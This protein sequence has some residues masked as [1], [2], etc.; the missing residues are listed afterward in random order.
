MGKKC[1]IEFSSFW[2]IYE[3]SAVFA[4]SG[5]DPTHA[6]CLRGGS[7][8]KLERCESRDGSAMMLLLL[9]LLLLRSAEC[10]CWIDRSR[11]TENPPP[12]HHAHAQ[13]GP[14]TRPPSG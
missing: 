1:V 9:L 6:I 3:N 8:G 5:S 4:I 7:P 14:A 13:R 11:S 10:V 12:T 2:C